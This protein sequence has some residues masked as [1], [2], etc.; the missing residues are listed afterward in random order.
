MSAFL[1]MSWLKKIETIVTFEKVFWISELE[2]IFKHHT[3]S[4]LLQQNEL[5]FLHKALHAKF[6]APV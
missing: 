4:Y 1:E 5:T 3:C 6:Q 2:R